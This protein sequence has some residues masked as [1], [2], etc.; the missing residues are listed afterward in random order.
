[1][2]ADAQAV[3]DAGWDESALHGTIA[4]CCMANFMNRLV[5]GAGIVADPAMFELRGAQAVKAGYRKPFYA[6]MEA[7]AKAARGG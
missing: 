5:E 2:P 7:F 1:V 6:K 3:F 4:L